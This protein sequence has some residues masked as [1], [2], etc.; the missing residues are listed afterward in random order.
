MEEKSLY[1]NS[2]NCI[3]ENNRA[4]DSGGVVYIGRF[5]IYTNSSHCIFRNNLAE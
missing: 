2:D 1:S 3:F 5:S 4:H